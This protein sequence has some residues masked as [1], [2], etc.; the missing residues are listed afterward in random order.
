MPIQAT[1]QDSFQVAKM[2]A[3]MIEGATRAASIAAADSPIGASDTW[4]LQK[5]SLDAALHGHP[6]TTTEFAALD[7]PRL[8]GN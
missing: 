8:S 3:R 7:W 6:A 2:R 1:S 5:T 4:R